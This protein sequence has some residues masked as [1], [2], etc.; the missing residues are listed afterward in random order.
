MDLQVLHLHALLVS[1][2]LGVMSS[3]ELQ[4]S[5]A[6]LCRH[7]MASYVA[8]EILQHCGWELRILKDLQ[9][10]TG[11][12]LLE[13]AGR[14]LAQLYRI[15]DRKWVPVQNF[16][17]PEPVLDGFKA[18]MKERCSSGGLELTEQLQLRSAEPRSL[19]VAAERLLRYVP[20]V[21]VTGATPWPVRRT[22]WW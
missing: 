9:T 13:T 1:Q 2:L 19:P 20:Q 10:E 18:A 8:K 6:P 17:A 11:E 14:V 3:E 5:A 15:C 7:D 22:C 21:P 16:H 12:E 4:G